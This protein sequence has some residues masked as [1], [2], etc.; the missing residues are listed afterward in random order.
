MNK[1]ELTQAARPTMTVTIP[2]WGNASI[3][4]RKLDAK[5]ILG[6][7]AKELS[8]GNGH[9]EKAEPSQAENLARE[10]IYSIVDEATGERMFE[11]TPEDVATVLSFG[12]DG[13]ARLD[14]IITDFNR[15]N[16]EDRA[17]NS[18]ASQ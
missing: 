1:A 5:A 6:F 17:K 4:I 2:E 15:H 14:R 13:L 18:E 11:D 3:T 9:A 7:A 10:V 12:F 16:L 8:N